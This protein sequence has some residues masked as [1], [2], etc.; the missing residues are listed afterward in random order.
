MARASAPSGLVPELDLCVSSRLTLLAIWVVEQR[1]TSRFFVAL[2]GRATCEST[3]KSYLTAPLARS[4][5]SA[6]DLSISPLIVL[7][8]ADDSMCIT[9]QYFWLCGHPAT[10]RFRTQLCQ[11][12]KGRICRI[13]DTNKFLEGACRKCQQVRQKRRQSSRRKEPA[14][15]EDTWYIPTRC[16]VDIGYRT[17][18]PFHVNP[19]CDPISP[20]TS[21]PPYFPIT[22]TSPKT[23]SLWGTLRSP[24]VEKSP[25]ERFFP[26]LRWH[27][28]T[29]PCCD[30][31]SLAD[32]I[33]VVRLEEFDA[34]IEGR[35]MDNH[36]ESAM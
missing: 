3:W 2:T 33:Q 8:P 1:R 11:H 10:H 36:C 31:L 17:L 7:T 16:F 24:R 35:I 18:D 12:S 26:K 25:L 14:A 28:K 19:E 6:S 5:T 29:S 13:R 15:F 22:P 27:K 30:E 20:L 4:P 23:E 34:R 21:V 9:T 32:A